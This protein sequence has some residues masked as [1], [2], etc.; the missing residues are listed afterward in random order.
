MKKVGFIVFML[1]FMSSS[2]FASFPVDKAKLKNVKKQSNEVLSLHDDISASERPVSISFDEIEASETFVSPAAAHSGNNDSELVILLLLW[3][4]LG[5]L[6]GHRWYAGKPVLY[7]IL[8][9]ITLGGLG[10][11]WIIDLI[12]ILQGDF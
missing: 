10:V 5:G 9:I 7:N 11:W 1:A 4:F 8:F 6:A 12:H 2:V 3:F